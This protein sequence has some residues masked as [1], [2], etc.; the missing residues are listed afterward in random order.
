MTSKGELATQMTEFAEY[1]KN[2]RRTA[3]QKSIKRS[4]I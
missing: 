1:F 2:E 4:T 3:K